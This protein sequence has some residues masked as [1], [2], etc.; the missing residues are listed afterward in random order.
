MNLV[1][2]T[3]YVI[4]HQEGTSG[5][6]R[7]VFKRKESTVN[8]LE[9]QEKEQTKGRKMATYR[10]GRRLIRVGPGEKERERDV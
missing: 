10:P 5:I 9:E 2:I 7:D 1:I 6:A 3:N 8:V 4:K